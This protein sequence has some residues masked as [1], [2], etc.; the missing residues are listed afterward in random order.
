MGWLTDLN[1]EFPVSLLEQIPNGAFPMGT[2]ICLSA[3]A[4]PVTCHFLG[5]KVRGAGSDGLV[6]PTAVIQPCG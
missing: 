5:C 6:T 2:V 4:L 1:I 3:A